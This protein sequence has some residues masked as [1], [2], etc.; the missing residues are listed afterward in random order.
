MKLTDKDIIDNVMSGNA[1]SKEAKEVVDWYASSIEGQKYLS[2]MID[3]DAYLFESEVNDMPLLSK[4]HSDA[5]FTEIKATINKRNNLRRYLSFA[6]IVIPFIFIIGIGIDLITQ[7]DL[8]GKAEYKELY[9]P[10]G[11][12]AHVYFQDGTEMYL[13]ADSRIK[14]PEKFGLTR[15]KVYLE[16]EAYFNVTSNK[17]RPFIVQTAGTEINVLGT[18]FNVNAYKE[19]EFI[20]VVLDEGKVIFNTPISDY[21]ILPGQHLI[22]NKKSGRTELQNLSKSTNH[23]LW[24]N[25]IL[26]LEDTPLSE[27]IQLLERRYNVEFIVKDAN[28]LVYTYTLVTK[29]VSVE[30]VLKE[31]QKIA[32]VKF[33]HQGSYIEVSL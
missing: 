6:A 32:P 31:L 24:K 23:S 9:I 20:S 3:R 29:Q 25:N 8:F 19:D 14:Y 18:S 26:Y 21:S 15:R 7:F 12:V 17:Q 10:K 27:V 2:D 28:A 1:T 11:E 13:N 30:N 33:T 4:D 5:L 22:Y 16:G